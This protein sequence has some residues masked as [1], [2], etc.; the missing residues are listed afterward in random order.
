[1][2]ELDEIQVAKTS[3]YIGVGV[4]FTPK[5][6]FNWYSY[7]GSILAEVPHYSKSYKGLFDSQKLLIIN[8]LEKQPYLCFT[9]LTDSGL[10]F[11]FSYENLYPR[12]GVS[13]EDS[14]QVLRVQTQEAV[15]E[16]KRERVSADLNSLSLHPEVQNIAVNSLECD[17]TFLCLHYQNP[18]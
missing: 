11:Y 16:L 13:K 10:G 15:F 8:P 18:Q 17:V 9:G 7:P 6:G 5:E 14:W 4:V 12:R 2:E 3:F 1:M